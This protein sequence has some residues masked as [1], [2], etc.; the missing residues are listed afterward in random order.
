MFFFPDQ[1]LGRNTGCE[2]RHTARQDGSVE[3]AR[4][5][6]RQYRGTIAQRQAHSLAGPLLGARTVQGLARGQDPRAKCP[7]SRCSC[8]PNARARSSK[9]ATSTA[10]PVTS[11]RPSKNSPT[12]S[13]WAIGTEVNLVNSSAADRFPDKEIHLLAPDLCMCAT[14]YRIAPA[15]PRLGDRESARRQRRQRDRRR[16]RDKDTSP[17]SPSSA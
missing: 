15:K 2:I 11:S 17:T 14:M 3:S 4:R 7:A 12:G 10:R 6:W 5:A 16:R 9:R 13:K 1:H 8:I